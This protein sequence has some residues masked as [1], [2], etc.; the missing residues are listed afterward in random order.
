MKQLVL[1]VVLAACGD[2]A[3]APPVDGGDPL[4]GTTEL[5]VAVP[6][7]VSLS[8]TD[9]WDLSFDG[10]S[11]FT[12]GGASGSGAGGAF[13]PLDL[14]DFASD[15]APDV[16]FITADAAGGAFLDWY[17]YDGTSHIL[18]SRYHVYGVQR[19]AQLTKVQILTYYGVVDGTPT[20]A[21]YQVR[22]ADLTGGGA[23]RTLA[24][25]GTAGGLAGSDDAPSGCLELATGSVVQLA[26][27]E[28]MTSTDWDL[29]FRRDAISV[30]GEA[31]GP[32]GVG[33]FD[34]DAA[35][36]ADL[37]AV[38][39]ETADG[40]QPAFDAATSASFASATFRGDHVVSAFES[41]GWVDLTASPPVPVA[42][43]WLVVGA[44]GQ[45]FLVSFGSFDNA[46][47]S[48]PGTVVLH[49]KPVSG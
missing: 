47:T 35:D 46:T 40:E 18:Y 45:K 19:G 33:A 43:A 3:G 21:M 16:P 49:F 1:L 2:D 29:C 12:N 24:I 7:R 13:G 34:L 17:A 15:A 31:G 36:P 11:I 44:S 9:D 23:T 30:N 4:A 42:G 39:A 6:S 28:A 27:A 5:D 41:G 22:F 25:D 26:P 20:S 14:S 37:A 10:Y 32:G 8:G 38:M 48:S